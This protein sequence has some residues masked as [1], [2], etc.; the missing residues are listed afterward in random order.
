MAEALQRPIQLLPLAFAV[1][2]CFG[3]VL[4]TFVRWYVLVR[5][6]NLPFSVANSVR[7]GLIGYFLS[8]FLPGSI[9]GDIIKAAFIAR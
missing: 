9:G 1:I 8:T 7:L 4:L 5:A 3:S 2:L 6:Q